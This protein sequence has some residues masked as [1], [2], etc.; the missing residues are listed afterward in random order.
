MHTVRGHFHLGPPEARLPRAALR[1]HVEGG[2]RGTF[3]AQSRTTAVTATAL[4]IA[5]ATIR[6]GARCPQP[7]TVDGE[8]L[9]QPVN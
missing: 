8:S 1:A 3:G 5:R 6:A 4:A 2:S 9:R 7:E